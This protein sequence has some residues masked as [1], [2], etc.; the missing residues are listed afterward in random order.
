MESKRVK[1]GLDASD[2]E[3]EILSLLLQVT[4]GS[5]FEIVD[6]SS[7]S[8]FDFMLTKNKEDNWSLNQS[9]DQKS[10]DVISMALDFDQSKDYKRV[11]KKKE[12]LLFKALGQPKSSLNVLDLTCGLAIDAVHFASLQAQVTSLERNPILYFLLKQAQKKCVQDRIQKINI[13]FSNALT[14]L[15]QNE[16]LHRRFDAVYFDPMYPEKKKKSAKPRKEMQL[17]RNFVGDDQDAEEVF[18]QMTRTEVP[19]LIVKRP[20]NSE[21]L[22]CTSPSYLKPI[23]YQGKLVRYDVYRRK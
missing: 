14:F 8:V 10:K 9:Q 3:S 13:Q 15:Q 20:N 2:L 23:V 1:V 5:T 22:N 18:Q 19:R 12:D 16:D 4:K 17:F 11:V 7:K 21:I 6:M